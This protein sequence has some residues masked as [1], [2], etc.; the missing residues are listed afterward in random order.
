VIYVYCCDSRLCFYR[1]RCAQD[2]LD[3]VPQVDSTFAPQGIF[4]RLGKN[5]GMLLGGQ[6]WAPPCGILC[7]AGVLNLGWK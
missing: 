1:A 6:R 4:C 3:L 7:S 5:L 2:Y